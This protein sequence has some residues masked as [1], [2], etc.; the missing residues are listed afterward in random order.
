MQFSQTSEVFL[1]LTHLAVQLYMNRHT[2]KS[3]KHQ[4]DGEIFYYR[5]QFV[6]YFKHKLQAVIY[7]IYFTYNKCGMC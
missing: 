2:R 6:S 1:S 5:Q 3:L 4:Q 7:N